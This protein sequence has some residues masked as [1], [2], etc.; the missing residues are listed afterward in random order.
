MALK[1]KKSKTLTGVV[2]HCSSAQTIKVAILSLKSHDRYKKV[3]KMIS[4]VTVHDQDN[5]AKVGDNVVI[6]ACKPKSKSKT[7][8]LEKV[9]S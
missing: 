1:E 2:R 4:T 8:E 6:K 5:V 3:L 7:W 9:L